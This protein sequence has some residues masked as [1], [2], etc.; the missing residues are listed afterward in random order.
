MLGPDQHIQ[1]HLS[2]N[3]WIVNPFGQFRKMFLTGLMDTR[4]STADRVRR[5]EALDREING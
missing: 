3:L 5:L 1:G 4:P 2:A